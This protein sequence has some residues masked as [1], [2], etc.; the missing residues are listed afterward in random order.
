MAKKSDTGT[1]CFAF[2]FTVILIYIM[3]LPFLFDFNRPLFW[4]I[5]LIPLALFIGVPVIIII[6]STINAQESTRK[7]IEKIGKFDEQKKR[8]ASSESYKYLVNF[9]RYY[10]N[11]YD[12]EGII[13]P[14]EL[15]K[16]QNLLNSKGFQFDEIEIKMLVEYENFKE[17]ITSN[18][19][20]NLREYCENFIKSYAEEY[21]NHKEF[22]IDILK[23]NQVD[24]NPRE[25]DKIL[26]QTKEEIEM[27]EFEAGITSKKSITVSSEKIDRLTGYEFEHFL[28]NVF[29]KMDYTVANTKLSGDQG[30]D[31]II[32]KAGEKIVV[33]AKKHT[34]KIT[35]K[36]IQ[37]VVAAIKHYNA[38]KGMVVTN[39]FF[40][41][42]A[43]ELAK[44]NNV[45]LIDRDK[46]NDLLK[47]IDK[48][49][50]VKPLQEAKNDTN[51]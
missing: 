26:E 11:K 42:S 3:S 6:V 28:K 34:N 9:A 39:N 21:L 37:E 30:A 17:K 18:M 25:I 44:S 49:D 35:N 1:G 46:L 14:K 50:I 45:E 16:L 38:D 10:K 2:I 20:R 24:F 23:E 40:T 27:A 13:E 47:T 12:E 5:L 43:V 22:F 8:F 7:M 41:R 15:T 51:E 29:E 31:L 36:A 48:E 4:K 19:P 33:Q 32:S